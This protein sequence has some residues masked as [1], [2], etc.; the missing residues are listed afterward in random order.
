MKSLIGTSLV[1]L[2]IMVALTYTANSADNHKHGQNELEDEE[3][4]QE[5]KDKGHQE[6]EEHGHESSKFGEGKAITEVK[7]EGKAFKLSDRAERVM[8]IKAH[9][10]RGNE[11][12]GVF[13]IPLAALVEFQDEQGIFVRRDGWYT[14]VEVKVIKNE[15]DLV[16]IQSHDLSLA[17]EIITGGVPL[18]RVAHLEASGKGGE[19][20]GH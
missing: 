12:K 6:S 16:T 19:G 15:K 14:L 9:T 11:S 1:F 2:T 18:L 13:T 5:K 7:G 17:D 20:H 3:K 4:H 10:F 8:E